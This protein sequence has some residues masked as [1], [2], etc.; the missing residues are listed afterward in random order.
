MCWPGSRDRERGTATAELAVVLPAL[1][2]VTLA[3]VWVVLVGAAQLRCVDAAGVGARAVARGETVAEVERV[4][5]RAA[6]EGAVLRIGRDTGLVVVEV[7]ATVPLPVPWPG[8]G[9][10]VEVGDSAVALAEDPP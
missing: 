4:V 10:G 7:R 6:P 8:R 3:G 2:L 5:A 9:G 1:V